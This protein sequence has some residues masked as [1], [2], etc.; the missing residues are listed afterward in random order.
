MLLVPLRS[1]ALTFGV[2]PEVFAGRARAAAT[3]GPH[4]WG[5]PPSHPIAHRSKG[6]L[7]HQ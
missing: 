6:T 4:A 5:L 3:M 2:A 1:P 7:W